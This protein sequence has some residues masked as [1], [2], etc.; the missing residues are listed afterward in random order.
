MRSFAGC[1]VV[2]RIV[3]FKQVDVF[4]A[5]PYRG[6]PVAVILDG[7]GLS[8]AQMQ[9]LAAWTNLSE[10]TFVLPPT[11]A[12]ADYRLRI[13]T[14][15]QEL[16]FAGHPSV[17]SAHA[18]LEA[19]FARQH[20][21]HLMMECKAGVLRIAVEGDQADRRIHVRVPEARVEEDDITLSVALAKAL[22]VTINQSPAPLPINVGPTWVVVDL[23]D[24][25]IVR[26]L[27]PDMARLAAIEQDF[28]GVGVT[29]FGRQ[30]DP[31]V[32]LVVRSFA[33]ADGVPEDPVC[34]SGNAAV[35]A[36][37]RHY[38]LVDEGHSGYAASQG[39][40]VGRDGV[41]RVRYTP[42]GGIEIGGQA[43]TCIDGTIRLT[44]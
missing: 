12:G 18:I 10:T 41:V 28:G 33:P 8:D 9:Q 25:A 32:P 26:K 30:D 24:A 42:D 16:P 6:N 23:E 14:P 37:L 17:G 1:H 38:G 5:V 27:K 11:Q 2:M 31:D 15:R 20:E 34:G 36:F 44:G 43:V 22:G 29:V 3:P 35:A 4:T 19:G 7:E 40:E 39:R 13:F 21:A